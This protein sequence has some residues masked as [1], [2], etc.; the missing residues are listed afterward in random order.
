MVCVFLLKIHLISCLYFMCDIFVM[1]FWHSS[2]K[3]FRSHLIFTLRCRYFFSWCMYRVNTCC[4]FYLKLLLSNLVFLNVVCNSY[5]LIT[6]FKY[7]LKYSFVIIRRKI[8]SSYTYPLN[9]FLFGRVSSILLWVGTI[10]DVIPD[11]GGWPTPL[12][13]SFSVSVSEP[14][15]EKILLTFCHYFLFLKSPN[16]PP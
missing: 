13:S 4:C 6:G 5:F 9:V 1:F 15:L 16:F 8:L 14:E 10:R 3:P 11:G 7:P 2:V 12:L